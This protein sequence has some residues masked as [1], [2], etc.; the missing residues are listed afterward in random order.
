M[1]SCCDIALYL[2]EDVPGRQALADV[3]KR[4][5]LHYYRSVSAEQ[6]ARGAWDALERALDR[7]APLGAHSA[8]PSRSR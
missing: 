6:F 1:I 2:P 7:D 5:R 8:P 3:P 4:L